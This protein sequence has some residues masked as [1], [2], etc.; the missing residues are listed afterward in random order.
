MFVKKRKDTKAMWEHFRAV[1]NGSTSSENGLAD[2][3]EIE[4]ECFD[5]SQSV[6]AKINYYFTS[7]DTIL[8]N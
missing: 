2:E 8:N 4:V 6:A 7:V 1:N 5:D 3:L